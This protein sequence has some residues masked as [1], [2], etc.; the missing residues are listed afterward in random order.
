[1]DVT[2]VMPSYKPERSVVGYVDELVSHGFDRI[3]VVDDGSGDTFS[4]IF[5]ELRAKP[6]CIVLKHEGNRG[7]GMALKTG[8]SFVLEHQNGSLGVVTADS[9]GQHSVEDCV[10]MAK[11]LLADADTVFIGSREFSFGKMPFRSWFGNRWS[12]VTFALVLGKWL[13]DTQTGLRAFPMSILPMLVSVAGER[14]EYEMGVLMKLVRG[15]VPV[16]P[17]SISTI[18][19]NGN[20]CSHFNPLKDTIRINRLVLGDFVRFAGV[21]IMSF[22]LDQALAWGFA[23]ALTTMGFSMVG[24]IWASGFAARLISSVFNFTLNRSFVFR[25]GCDIGAA[26][27]K[28]ALLC[29]AVIVLSNVG[30]MAL[31]FAG[32]PRG[33]AKFLCDVLLYFAGYGI[34]SNFIFRR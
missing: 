25:S 27:W 1:M 8:L 13:P 10:R 17:L 3:V 20:A 30:V 22:M 34:Q 33:A 24:M 28:Y 16:R 23:T 18:Y 21:S 14:Y 4:E 11:A 2:I 6:S 15:N 12:S 26:A 29:V 19:E 5:D 9:D 7:K 31:S 32:V